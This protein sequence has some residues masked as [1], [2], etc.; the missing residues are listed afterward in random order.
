MGLTLAKSALTRFP[1][2]PDHARLALV[3]M[4]MQALDTPRNNTPAAT[5]YGG[6]EQLASTLYGVDEPT[7]ADLKRLQRSMKVLRQVGAVRVAQAACRGR[8]A[9]Y[10][11]DV[12][13]IPNQDQL[14]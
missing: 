3:A 2:L 11:L 12:T 10:R 14:I 5:Y 4:S 13:G 8:T 1:D 7:D 9:V 6:H